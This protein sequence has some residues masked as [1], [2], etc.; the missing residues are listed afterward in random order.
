MRTMPK[1]KP[2]KKNAPPPGTGGGREKSDELDFKTDSRR[3]IIVRLRMTHPPLSLRQIADKL[4]CSVDT[5]MADIRFLRTQFTSE[6]FADNNRAA[7]ARACAE[8]QTL[9]AQFL[10]EA[11]NLPKHA[12]WT[13]ERSSLYGRALQALDQRNNIMMECGIINKAATK[14]ETSG[15]DGKP[16]MYDVTTMSIQ[17]RIKAMTLVVSPPEKTEGE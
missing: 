6:Y 15:P 10:T 16:I 9:A 12:N 2:K 14:I 7:V 11:E 3:Q 8:L 17:E 5:V 1:A 4:K 13:T